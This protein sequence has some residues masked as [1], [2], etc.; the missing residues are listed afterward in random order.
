MGVSVSIRA[1]KP[2]LRGERAATTRWHRLRGCSNRHSR[3][4]FTTKSALSY[5]FDLVADRGS[6]TFRWL[7]A[8]RG[9]KFDGRNEQ[10]KC[11]RAGRK[12]GGPGGGARSRWSFRTRD[13]GRARRSDRGDRSAQG[14]ATRQPRAWAVAFRLSHPRCVVSWDDGRPDRDWRNTWRPDRRFSLVPIRLL[15][16]ACPKRAG[17]H[18]RYSANA[19][20]QGA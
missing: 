13:R 19:R 7:L 4:T 8:Q 12:H 16:A 11:R 1:S 14:R 6:G 20:E 18:R 15:E 3:P 5:H 10:S 17:R 2:P 9:R